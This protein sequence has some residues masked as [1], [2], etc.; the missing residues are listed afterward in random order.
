[1]RLNPR[2]RALLTG[3]GVVHGPEV[4]LELEIGEENPNPRPEL[5]LAPLAPRV[6]DRSPH[7]RHQQHRLHPRPTS[8]AAPPPP[9]PATEPGDPEAAVAEHPRVEMETRREKVDMRAR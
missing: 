1:M 2:A 5:A 4:L 3:V 8:A 7:S 9:A 6:Q